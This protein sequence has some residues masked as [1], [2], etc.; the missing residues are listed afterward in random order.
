MQGTTRDISSKRNWKKQVA[1][2]GFPILLLKFG[3]Q[4][5]LSQIP[6]A[7]TVGIWCLASVRIKSTGLSALFSLGS[8][9]IDYFDYNENVL[10]SKIF[11]QQLWAPRIKFN[12]YFLWIF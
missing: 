7:A 3:H 12:M 8:F 2:W 4:E 9:W 6:M 1:H 10:A 5:L 11:N